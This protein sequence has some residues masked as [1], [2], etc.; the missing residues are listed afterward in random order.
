M[1]CTA[2]RLPWNRILWLFYQDSSMI[3]TFAL[4]MNIEMIIHIKMKIKKKMMTKMMAP[5]ISALGKE[6]SYAPE[7]TSS[8][9]IFLLPRIYKANHYMMGSC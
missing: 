1:F 7:Q 2:E 4:T 5:Y 6:F 3:K 8:H 9:H